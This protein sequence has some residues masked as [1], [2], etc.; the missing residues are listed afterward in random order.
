MTEPLP[1]R[2]TPE[3]LRELPTIDVLTQ[4]DGTEA[5]RDRARQ[6]GVEIRME[7][8]LQAE[9]ESY[10]LCTRGV[11]GPNPDVP[12][13]WIVGNVTIGF[14]DDE[15]TTYGPDNVIAFQRLDYMDILKANLNQLC[16]LDEQEPSHE[17]KTEI[18]KTR[19]ELRSLM[20]IPPESLESE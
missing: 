13:S 9:D 18:D 1:I 3:K 7:L 14:S 19:E 12:Q 8:K 5:W 16:E 2:P 17:T 4:D 20:G 10:W 11:N 6:L 15:V